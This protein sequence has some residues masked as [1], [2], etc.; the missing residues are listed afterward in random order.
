MTE[1]GSEARPK[2][3]WAGGKL[4]PG[5]KQAEAESFKLRKEEMLN[6]WN[7]LKN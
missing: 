1:T 6:I 7:M 4:E 3:G 2:A 5:I